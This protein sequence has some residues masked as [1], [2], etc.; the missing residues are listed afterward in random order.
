MAAFG[1]EVITIPIGTKLEGPKNWNVWK[2][3]VRLALGT[4]GLMGI[5]DGTQGK[6]GANAEKKDVDT[7]VAKVIKA[8]HIIVTR[9]AM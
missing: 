2:F 8:Q 7:W 9:F 5:V 1:T 4:N 6:P 3:Q